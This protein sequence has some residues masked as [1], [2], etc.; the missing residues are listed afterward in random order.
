MVICQ[1]HLFV[2]GSYPYFPKHFP[3]NHQPHQ[4]TREYDMSRVYDELG[5]ERLDDHGKTKQR[6]WVFYKTINQ[7]TPIYLQDTVPNRNA[8]NHYQLHN[9]INYPNPRTRT[10][11]FQNSFKPT[12]VNDWNKL[13]ND[14]KASTS[15]D[16]FTNKLNKE[17][18]KKNQVDIT[19]VIS[20]KVY[21][22][23]D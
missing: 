15:L 2:S 19:Q 13:D 7:D 4:L 6:L 10:S 22:M 21:Y 3:L 14:M 11:P 9:N 17:L 5:W 20:D 8:Q 1:I 12:T 18:T 16:S 23:L